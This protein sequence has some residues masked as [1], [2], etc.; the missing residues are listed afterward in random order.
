MDDF[1][2]TYSI[3]DTEKKKNNEIKKTDSIVILAFF[4]V[5]I[6]SLLFIIKNKLGIDSET[7]VILRLSF[8]I[9]ETVQ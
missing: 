7:L 9:F 6:F 1:K 4:C 3:I 8:G 2:E 5:L